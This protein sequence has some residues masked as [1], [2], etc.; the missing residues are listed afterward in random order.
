MALSYR[1]TDYYNFFGSNKNDMLW[2][3]IAGPNVTFLKSTRLHR[4]PGAA[5]AVHETHA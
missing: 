2:K 1:E 5:P 4:A 3:R